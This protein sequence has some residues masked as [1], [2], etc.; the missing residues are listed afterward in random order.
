M[1]R[2]SESLILLL[3]EFIARERGTPQKVTLDMRLLESGIIDSFA[4][5]RLGE[6]VAV[7]FD[8]EL[9]PGMLVPEDFE[10][11]GILWARLQEIF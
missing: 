4:L 11:P 9:T 3:E 10:T 7:A 5:V 8:L 6:E 2:T 1:E